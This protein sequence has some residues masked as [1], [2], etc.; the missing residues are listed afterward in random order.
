MILVY[1]IVALLIFLLGWGLY[2]TFGP[3]KEDLK[4][5]IAEHARMHEMGIAH[6]HEGKALWVEKKGVDMPEHDHD[7]DTKKAWEEFEL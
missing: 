4:D 6:G 2:L 1:I 7:E 3:G 5:G